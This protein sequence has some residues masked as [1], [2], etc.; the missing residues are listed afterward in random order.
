METEGSFVWRIFCCCGG[1]FCVCFF[2]EFGSWFSVFILWSLFSCARSRA[3]V[4]YWWSFRY[5]FALLS[6]LKKSEASVVVRPA[7]LS[8]TE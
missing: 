6:S 7:R 1:V 8:V 3:V 5:S 4:C 2:L